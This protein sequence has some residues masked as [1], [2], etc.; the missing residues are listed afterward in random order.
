MPYLS[1]GIYTFWLSCG[2]QHR[3]GINFFKTSFPDYL[4]PYS[5]CLRLSLSCEVL[6]FHLDLCS[7]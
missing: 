4:K 2:K 7:L 5:Q 3:C 1:Q 6:S